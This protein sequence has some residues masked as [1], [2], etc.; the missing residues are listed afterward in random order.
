MASESNILGH[1]VEVVDLALQS[2][3]FVI[4]VE[5]DIDLS[6]DERGYGRRDVHDLLALAR[7]L[8]DPNGHYQGIRLV[9]PAR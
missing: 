7:R 8:F 3:R 4:V 2:T 6:L 9:P 5:T 1:H